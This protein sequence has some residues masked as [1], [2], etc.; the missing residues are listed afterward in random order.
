MNKNNPSILHELVGGVERLSRHLTIIEALLREQPAGIIKIAQLTKLPEHKVRYS[1]RVLEKSG[2][3]MPSREGA[4]LTPEF[5]DDR[6]KIAEELSK[7]SE[8]IS[9][10]LKKFRNSL[11]GR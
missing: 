4:I 5:V 11:L 6:E 9:K 1:L 10:E 7:V 3:I 8:D 2:I